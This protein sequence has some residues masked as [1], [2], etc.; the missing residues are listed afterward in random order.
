MVAEESLDRLVNE[1][2]NGEIP[3]EETRQSIESDIQPRRVVLHAGD[4]KNTP[5]GMITF[6][7]TLAFKEVA[8]QMMSTRPVIY[9]VDD[10]YRADDKSL[11]GLAI[12]RDLLLELEWSGVNEFWLR[13][14]GEEHY[15]VADLLSIRDL[16]TDEF[17]PIWG[18]IKRL[19]TKYWGVFPLDYVQLYPLE[20][21]I[22]EDWNIDV[23]PL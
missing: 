18:G 19:E 11:D 15:Y 10:R 8:R 6:A 16:G 3:V 13:N 1:M 2:E 20:E 17:N 4:G 14:P 12:S 5:Y 22:T 23:G 21:E 7:V 9:K